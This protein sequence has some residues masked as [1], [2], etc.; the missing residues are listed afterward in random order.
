[1]QKE[2]KDYPFA[3][4]RPLWFLRVLFLYKKKKFISD[5]C[6]NKIQNSKSVAH[7]NW[8]NCTWDPWHLWPR[9]Q[10]H[11]KTDNRWL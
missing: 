1:M 2:I 11:N 9:H 10:I 6:W 4:T 8:F 5:L 7:C 3:K